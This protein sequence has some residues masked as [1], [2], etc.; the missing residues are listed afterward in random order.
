MSKWKNGNR[1]AWAEL[2]KDDLYIAIIYNDTEI[3]HIVKGVL[4]VPSRE[5]VWLYERANIYCSRVKVLTFFGN[6]WKI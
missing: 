6:N 1:W 2:K 5:A 4:M 3:L